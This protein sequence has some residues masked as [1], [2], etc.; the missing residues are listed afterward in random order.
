MIPCGADA[1]EHFRVHGWMRVRAAFSGD[2]AAAMRAATWDA[3]AS[4]GIR[5]SDP[6]TWTMERPEHLQGLK[7][8]AAFR[9]VG[10]AHA[11]AMIETALN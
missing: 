2:E 3:L 10:S 11:I 6:S 9:A 7:A 5:E 4:A 1:P 8:H